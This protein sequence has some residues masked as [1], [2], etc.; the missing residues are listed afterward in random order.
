MSESLRI[1]TFNLESLDDRPDLEV[2]LSARIR[3]LRPQLQRLEADVLCLQEVNGQH[4]PGGGERRLLA[5]DRLLAETPYAGYHRAVSPRVAGPEEDAAAASHGVDAVHNLVILSRFEIERS[6]ALHHRLVLP[7]LYRSM[8][9]RPPEREPR[10]VVWDRPILH[11]TL[12]LPDGRRLHVVN[13]HLR[14][15][16]AAPIAGQKH[17]ALRWKSISGWAEGFYI[18]TMKR[19][20]QALETRLL[21]ERI[22]DAE[23]DALIAV[24]GDFNAEARQTPLR[25]IRG[26]AGDTGNPSL[27]A[28]ALVPLER[29]VPD[30]RR[31]SVVHGGRPEML[32]HMLVSRPLFRCCEAVAVHNE[33]L[34][35]ELTDTGPQSHHAP[36]VAGF[37]LDRA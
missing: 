31:F 6:E 16:L 32:D 35:D 5:L 26:D 14:A 27:E 13:L 9:A 36:L 8:T 33:D 24:C 21:V 30:A 19:A 3:I 29:A 10:P 28:R 7:P 20:G 15:P 23:P 4:P 37:D 1:A 22:F 2:P 34:G 18:A 11:A 25:T 12:E 17:D